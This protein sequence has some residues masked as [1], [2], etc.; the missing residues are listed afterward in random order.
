MKNIVN[1]YI[2][3]LTFSFSF[4]LIFEYRCAGDGSV[5]VKSGKNC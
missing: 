2:I 3:P 5:T 4:L 1:M